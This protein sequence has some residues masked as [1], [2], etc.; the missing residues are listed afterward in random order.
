MFKRTDTVGLKKCNFCVDAACPKGSLATVSASGA[1]LACSIGIP[2]RNWNRSYVTVPGRAREDR[3]TKCLARR[4][5]APQLQGDSS[6]PLNIPFSGG[7]SLTP[8][9]PMRQSKFFFG[10]LPYLGLPHS[11]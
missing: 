3:T 11:K 6:R 4:Q 10:Q 7:N 8:P 9:L 1:S 5:R 2:K